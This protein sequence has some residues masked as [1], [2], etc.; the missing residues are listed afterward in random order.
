M[1]TEEV[2][3]LLTIPS[4]RARTAPIFKLALENNLDYFD[5]D[6][7]QVDSCV[8][9]VTDVIN[10]DFKGAYETIP[11]HGRWGHLN[12]G[13][14][15]R[16]E[17]LIKQWRDSK[18]DE[19]E[20]GKR[21]IDL[22]VFSVLI[23]AGAGNDWKYVEESTGETFNR[24]EG[25]AIVSIDLFKNGAFSADKSNPH[26]IN[27]SK[28]IEFTNEDLIKSFQISETNPL[29]G[30][31]GRLKL[32][33]NLG[34]ALLNK[35][36]F[37]EDGRPG[38][39]IDYL[40]EKADKSSG[41]A[42]IDLTLLWDSL[43]LGF[44]PIWPKGRTTIDGISLGDAWPLSTTKKLFSSEPR[45][46]DT[47][48]PFHKL[49]QW[50]CYS[51]L[52]PLKEYGYKFKILNESLQTGLPEY[53]NGGLFYDFKIIQLKPEFLEKGL[54]LSKEINSKTPEIPSFTP[55]DGVIVEWRAL[56][57]GFLDYFLPLIN[58]KLG[59]ELIL[60]QLIEAGSWK[61]GREI[62]AKL[63][64]ETKGPPIDLHSDGTVF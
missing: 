36:L 3:Y 48:V 54:K 52:Q 22:F 44:T 40:N 39:L 27:G 32:I 11:P 50:L 5:V 59:F 38:N 12:A 45:F 34:E 24:S 26:Q 29:S 13:G 4:V 60:P 41:S 61:S 6:L 8:E 28:L 23:D 33:Q 42:V 19:I 62:A 1:S 35:E 63:R 55:D 7:T 17:S 53:R 16:V 57:I 10:R 43:M 47:I 14:H 21:L 46:I 9:F 25:L 49:T 20:I 15:K 18:V 58:K 51:L 31:D 56:T 64:P 30:R 37:G 2:K